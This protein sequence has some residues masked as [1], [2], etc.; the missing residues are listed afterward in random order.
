MTLSKATET[1]TIQ[2]ITLKDFSIGL[3]KKTKSTNGRDMSFEALF[4]VGP[5]QKAFDSER[6][7]WNVLKKDGF[8]HLVISLYVDKISQ[9]GVFSIG[10]ELVGQLNSTNREFKNASKDHWG[11]TFNHLHVEGIDLPEFRSTVAIIDSGTNSIAGPKVIV[12]KLVRELQIMGCDKLDSLPKIEFTFED[13][14]F[15]LESKYYVEVTDSSCSLLISVFDLILD[16]KEH[17][18]LIG[19]PFFEKFSTSFNF[20]KNTITIGE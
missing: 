4:G 12:D 19:E 20:D 16:G 7:F 17:N 8:Q 18:W 9:L 13:E 15:Y 5:S 6:S 14:V 2:E 3:V 11:V 1:I 10:K